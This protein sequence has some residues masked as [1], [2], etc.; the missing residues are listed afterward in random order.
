MSQTLHPFNSRSDRESSSNSNVQVEYALLLTPK[1]QVEFLFTVK[2]KSHHTVSIEFIICRNN[3]QKMKLGLIISVA[4]ALVVAL[5]VLS[6][7]SLDSIYAPRSSAIS[8]HELVAVSQ[9]SSCILD[10]I[11]QEPASAGTRL[12]CRI[13]QPK[14]R[15]QRCFS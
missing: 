6:Q 15:T 7:V 3:I 11:P 8:L 12:R 5:P 4:L 9:L 1:M 13:L 14:V 10:S 2:V